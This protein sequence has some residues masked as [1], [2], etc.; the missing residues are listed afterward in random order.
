MEANHAIPQAKAAA[1]AD[2]IAP[3]IACSQP[4]GAVQSHVKESDIQALS[5]LNRALD[6]KV[7]DVV[8]T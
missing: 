8:H 3:Q 4:S 1:I 5:E 7:Y 6:K 2:V